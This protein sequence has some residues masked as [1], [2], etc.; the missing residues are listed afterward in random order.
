MLLYCH[1]SF[2]PFECVSIIHSVTIHSHAIGGILSSHIDWLSDGDKASGRRKEM[3]IVSP[4]EHRNNHKKHKIISSLVWLA[5]LP[6]KEYD[7]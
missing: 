2:H 7:F 6:L 3:N 5:I 4:Y 1:S